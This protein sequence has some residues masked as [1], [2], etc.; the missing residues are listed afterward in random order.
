M[1]I[2]YYLHRGVIHMDFRGPDGKRYRP[3][4]GCTTQKDAEIAAA[5]VIVKDHPLL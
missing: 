5:G 3:S 4:T 1:N 2:R